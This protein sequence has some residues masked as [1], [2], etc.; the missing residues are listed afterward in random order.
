MI[1]VVCN[2]DC[3]LNRVSRIF[4]PLSSFSFVLYLFH[5]PY[6]L[7]LKNGLL[8]LLGNHAQTALLIYIISPVIITG[9]ISKMAALIKLKAPRIYNIVSGKR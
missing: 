8:F 6:L 7:I 2:S 1:F 3:F 5:E 9:L 4:I